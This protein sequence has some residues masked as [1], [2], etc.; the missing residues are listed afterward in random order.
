MFLKEV[1]DA[2]NDW[3]DWILDKKYSKN[4]TIVKYY[5]ITI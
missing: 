2:Y 5:S 3:I 1:S 4:R